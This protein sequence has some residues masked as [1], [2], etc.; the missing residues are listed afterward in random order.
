M[1]L[2]RF[3][4]SDEDEFRGCQYLGGH[5]AQSFLVDYVVGNLAEDIST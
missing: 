3:Y 4:I 1:F 5:S 2:F